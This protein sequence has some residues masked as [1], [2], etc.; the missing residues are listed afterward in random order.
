MNLGIDFFIPGNKLKISNDFQLILTSLKCLQ[1]IDIKSLGYL[2]YND[3]IFYF[4]DLLIFNFPHRMDSNSL[5]SKKELPQAHLKRAKEFIR[6]IKKL[7]V[8]LKNL[9]GIL[10]RNSLSNHFFES[11]MTEDKELEQGK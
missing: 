6:Y 10:S 8:S 11:N 1:I 2:L 5:C 3:H 4:I 9:I 7:F